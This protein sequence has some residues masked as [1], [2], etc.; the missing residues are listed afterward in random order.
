MNDMNNF[1]I[2]LICNMSDE[3][4][5]QYVYDIIYPYVK[6][7][8]IYDV[9]YTYFETLRLWVPEDIINVIVFNHICKRDDREYCKWKITHGYIVDKSLINYF[10]L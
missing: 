10:G 7:N 9:I 2:E 6:K 3:Q 1:F 4:Y 5:H 8:D